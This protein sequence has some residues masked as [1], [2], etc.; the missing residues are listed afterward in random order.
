[1][2]IEEYT[3][4]YLQEE[5]RFIR[6]ND[7]LSQYHELSIFEKAIIF[8]YSEDGF[9]ELNERL[10]NDKPMSEFGIFLNDTLEKLPNYEGLVFRG[11]NL[12][13]AQIDIYINAHKNGTPVIEKAF[14]STSIKKSIAYQFGMCLFAIDSIKGKDISGFTKHNEFEVLFNNNSAFEVLD[15]EFDETNKYHYFK[16]LEV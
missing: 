1:M 8:K 4:I 11:V 16:L 13:P 12:S 6:N 9:L 15:Y 7:K 14:V 5:V 3:Q 10:R 2:S